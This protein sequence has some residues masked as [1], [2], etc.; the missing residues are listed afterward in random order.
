MFLSCGRLIGVSRGTM[1]RRRR[2]FSITSAARSI[3]LRESPCA[4]AAMV[5]IEHG[6]IAMP[7]QPWLPL[8]IVAPRSR[9]LCTLIVPADT[10]SPYFALRNGSRFSIVAWSPSSSR[11]R[12]RPYSETI[13]STCRPRSSSAASVRVAYI[14]PLAPVT[15][16]ATASRGRGE[17]ALP[18]AIECDHQRDEIQDADVSVQIERALDLREI[19]GAHER[20]LVDEHRGHGRHAGQIDRAERRDE[21]QRKATRDGRRVHQARDR[22]RCG[23]AEAHGDRAQA[24]RAIEL[25]ILARVQ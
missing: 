13:S 11:S 9:L 12:R 18:G 10:P 5:F 25:E 23:H 1:T 8:A 2:S 24:V 19:V 16:S 20:L 15:P 22:E 7:R 14:A 4:T 3:R 6:T 17:S 21:R